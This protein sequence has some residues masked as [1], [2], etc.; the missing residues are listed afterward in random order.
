MQVDWQGRKFAVTLT[1]ETALLDTRGQ[2]NGIA[3]N[4]IHS[5]DAAHL[6]AVA[7]AAKGAGIDS[8]AVIHDSFG[9]HAADTDRL[10][11]LLRET[12]VAQYRPDLLAELHAEIVAQLPPEA[13]DL[14]PQPPAL[15]S[16][17]LTEVLASQYLFS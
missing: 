13:A 5:F 4:L 3:P 15:G 7:R 10:I 1:T 12:F 6:R 11:G 14:V 8:L 16:L 2:A 17:D 9:T